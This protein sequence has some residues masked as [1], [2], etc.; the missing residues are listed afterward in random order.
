MSIKNFACFD[1]YPTAM[2][3]DTVPEYL[4]GISNTPL[5]DFI[6]PFSSSGS[7]SSS[8]GVSSSPDHDFT[9]GGQRARALVMHKSNTSNTT[10]WFRLGN[11]AGSTFLNQTENV[12]KSFRE[13]VGFAFKWRAIGTGTVS[14]TAQVLTAAR[15]SGSSVATGQNYSILAMFGNK[16]IANG[17]T[18]DRDFTPDQ[19]YYVEAVLSSS[20]ATGSTNTC[21][22]EL[23]IDG[24]L[25]NTRDYTVGTPTTST[26]NFVFFQWRLGPSESTSRTMQMMFAHFYHLSKG[27]DESPTAPFDNRLGPQKVRLASVKNVVSN[28]D[29]T[30]EGATNPVDAWSFPNFGNDGIYVQSPEDDGALSVQLQ[31]PTNASSKIH[32]IQFLARTQRE[33]MV[34]RPL[35]YSFADQG[36]AVLGS[37]THAPQGGA[38]LNVGLLMVTGTQTPDVDKLTHANLSNAVFTL[39]APVQ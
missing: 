24:E 20:L 4:G 31:L 16:M 37:G 36:G 7:A 19:E 29:W 6:I 17:T 27:F 35:N 3:S 28:D 1:L 26:N 14:A 12:G 21:T 38:P 33:G 25:I 30:T 9:V 32:G 13:V 11:G 22:I 10:N 23:W 8:L 2:L 34:S 5:K 18:L 39:R 15:H